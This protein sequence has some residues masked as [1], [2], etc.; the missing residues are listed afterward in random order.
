MSNRVDFFQSA[1][2]SLALP[3]A[4]VSIMV[5]GTASTALEPIEIVRGGWPEFSWASLSY[6][7]AA[8]ADCSVVRAEDIE[9]TIRFARESSLEWAHFA[10]FLPIPG[11]EDGDGW[12]G[13]RTAP[14]GGWSAFHNISCPAPPEGIS[15]SE[16][17]R[18]QRKA[19]T[20]FYMR[21]APLLRTLGL[22]FHRGT[23]TRMIRRMLAYLFG[24]RG[25]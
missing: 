23:A 17:K 20:R 24:G 6:N 15:R 1:Q 5:D 3:A 22:F 19:F 8:C 2:T 14:E 12:L 16:L 18:F 25:Y 7:P 21:P 13:G 9:A 11:S 10:S 4:S